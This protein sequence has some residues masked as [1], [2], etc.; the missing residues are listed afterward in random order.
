M[1]IPITLPVHYDDHDETINDANNQ[2]VYHCAWPEGQTYEQKKEKGEFACKVLNGEV[3]IV[4]GP[5]GY[6]VE[7]SMS[8]SDGNGKVQS[9]PRNP[10]G[11]AGKPK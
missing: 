6:E 2:V 5:F 9:I 11:R 3:R 7:D 1:N 8:V 4:V 10:W